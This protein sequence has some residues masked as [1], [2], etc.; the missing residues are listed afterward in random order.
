M[1]FGVNVL[2]WILLSATKDLGLYHKQNV[3]SVSG[4]WQ[5]LTTH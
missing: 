3:R 1:S 2:M 5:I 4:T